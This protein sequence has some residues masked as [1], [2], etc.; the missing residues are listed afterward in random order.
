MAG[1]IL[2]LHR[3]LMC[4]DGEDRDIKPANVLISTAGSAKLADFGAS[5]FKPGFED[6]NRAS[7]HRGGDDPMEKT[8]TGQESTLV[9]T[10][11][12][13][14]P[15]AISQKAAGRRSNVWSFGGFVLQSK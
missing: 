4:I 9:G 5:Q 7:D 13:M 8:D 14:S 11:Y 15:E 2:P 3:T 6:G 10:P 1:T 12:F